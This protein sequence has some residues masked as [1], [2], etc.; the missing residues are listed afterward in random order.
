MRRIV[1][2]GNA[3]SGKSTLS[4]KINELTN[5]PVYHLDKILWK[6]NWE[7]TPEDEFTVKHD[8]IISKDSWIIDG[9]A[10]KSSYPKR[11]SRATTI[12]FL[13]TPLEECKQRSLQRMKEDL[14]RPNPYVTEGCRYPLEF[15]N[16]AE[17]VIV[18]FH[19]E[20]REFILEMIKEYKSNTEII[21]LKS[22]KEVKSFL[23][24]L[25]KKK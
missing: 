3:A 10:Y 6:K 4:M 17:K 18:L 14:E 12:I 24:S 22:D 25:Q 2:I 20:Y 21:L 5:I 8:E 9:V 23:E 7:R 19:N 13:D 11:F 16:E 1:V 15:K